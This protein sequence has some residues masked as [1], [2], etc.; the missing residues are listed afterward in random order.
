MK[1]C[2]RGDTES[3]LPN[4]VST[5]AQAPG[6]QHNRIGYKGAGKAGLDG[7]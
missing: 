2:K 4:M 1:P 7:A 5:F 6:M 3:M